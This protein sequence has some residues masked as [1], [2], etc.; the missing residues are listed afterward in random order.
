MFELI[1]KEV[2]NFGNVSIIVGKANK[3]LFNGKIKCG[4]KIYE[5]RSVIDNTHEAP[6]KLS[7]QV[8]GDKADKSIIGKTFKSVA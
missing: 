6:D 4:N 8:W 3:P 5:V 2:F 7:F 1:V